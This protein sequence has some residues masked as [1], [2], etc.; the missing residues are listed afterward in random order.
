M[1][2]R[3]RRA[4]SR[5]AAA[6]RRKDKGG[7]RLGWLLL[8]LLLLGAAGG[9]LWA[10]R[11]GRILRG[12]STLRFPVVTGTR[13]EVQV[14]FADPRWTRLVPQRREIPGGLGP[15]ELMGRLVEELAKGPGEGAAPVLP[16]GA[17]LRGAYLGKGG[18][19]ILDFDGK[20]LEGFSPGGASG[21]LLTVFALVHT[22]AEG[23][24]GVREVQILVDGAERETLAGHVKISEPLAPNPDLVASQREER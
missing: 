1:A 5:R 15:A 7:R 21:E 13:T 6:R 19:A 24:P 8:V 11:S 4:A 14:F 22:V 16:A 2:Q 3:S 17:R 10:W 23:V 9:A 20:S 18:L 12:V